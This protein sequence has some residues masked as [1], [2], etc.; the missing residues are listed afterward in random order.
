MIKVDIK[1][2]QGIINEIIIKGHA[3]YNEYGKDIVCASVSSL[4]ICTVN[5]IISLEGNTITT[6][7]VGDTLTIKID[8]FTNINKKLIDNMINSLLQI[9]KDY[10]KNIK[11]TK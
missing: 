1:K 4:V 6:N 7:Y 3:N 5:A 9:E 2:D 8:K 10:S 11:I